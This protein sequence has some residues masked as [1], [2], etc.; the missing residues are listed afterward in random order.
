MERSS[1]LVLVIGVVAAVG[2]ALISPYLA[3]MALIIVGV[4]LM[5]LAIGHDTRDMPQLQIDLAEDARS[6]RIR[7]TG[8]APALAIQAAFVPLGVEFT[9]ASLAPEAIHEQV[10]P[11]QTPELKAVVSYQNSVGREF[12]ETAHL[13]ALHPEDDPFRPPFALFRWK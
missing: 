11:E 4:V 5:V 13:S 12:R 9:L 7:N 6:V 1:L 10:L 3:L 2:L 8:N